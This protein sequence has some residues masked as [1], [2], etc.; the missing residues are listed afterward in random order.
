MQLRGERRAFS[1]PAKVEP[2]I[3]R[4]PVEGDPISCFHADKSN[5]ISPLSMAPR[6]RQLS[7]FSRSADSGDGGSSRGT[8][9]LFS[10]DR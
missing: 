5:G 8:Y 9:T 2:P 4:I 6:R 3:C 1:T 7:N 10:C